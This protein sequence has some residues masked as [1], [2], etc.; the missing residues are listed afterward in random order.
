MKAQLITT[1]FADGKGIRTVTELPI[2]AEDTAVEREVVNLYPQ[3]LYQTIDGFGGAVT[4][5]VASV[6]DKAPAGVRGEILNR[7]FGEDGIGYSLVRIPLDSC[8]FSETMYEA[9]DGETLCPAPRSRRIHELVRQIDAIRGERSA[10]M[11]SPW[12]PPKRMKENGSRIGSRL[13]NE[14]CSDW[15]DYICRYVLACRDAGVD[16]QMLTVQNEPNAWQTWDSCLYTPQEERRFLMEFLVPALKRHGIGDLEICIWDHNK[17]RLVDRALEEIDSESDAHIAGLAFHWYSGDHFDALRIVGDLFP[18]KKLIFSEGCVEF[19]RFGDN[20]QLQSA[21]MYAHD[22]IGNLRAGATAFFDWNILL[23]EQ[24][25]PNHVDN[26][27]SAPLMYDTKKG[28]IIQNLTFDY[29]GHFSRY[30]RPGA[31][32]IGSTSYCEAV[33]QA[34][35]QNPDGSIAMVCCNATTEDRA[36]HLRLQGSIADFVLNANTIATVLI[37]P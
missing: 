12:S 35:V 31:R 18:G 22:Y 15:A 1:Q 29:I 32:R 36:V 21:Q 28:R 14:C 7:Y 17:E 37:E 4:D 33:E 25:G 3:A 5:A 16:V 11:L 30:I 13:K 23:D 8:D 34:A 6:L 9:E 10:V 26:F 19:S 20:S 27:C 2:R 24:G